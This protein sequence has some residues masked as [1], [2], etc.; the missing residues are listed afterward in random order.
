[1]GLKIINNSDF[2]LLEIEN[3][4]SSL[5]LKNYF[6]FI[7]KNHNKIKGDIFEFGVF[8]GSSLLST[9]LLL[10]SLN[11]KKKVIGFDSFSGFPDY[12]KQDSP[13]FFKKLYLKNQINREHY[14]RILKYQKILTFINKKNK[15]NQISTSGN[16]SNT[17]LQLLKKKLKFLNLSNVILVKG[18]F[19]ETIKRFKR[20]N[21]NINI[22]AANIDCD[23]YDGYKQSLEFIWEFAKKRAYIHLDEYYSLKFPGAKIATDEFLKNK[24][25]KV[26]KFKAKGDDFNRCYLIR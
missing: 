9:A 19:K 26:K 4:N 10:K 24:K 23:L 11:S 2:N 21:S 15:P 6:K 8:R 12:K 3:Y 1:M 17:S 14:N 25:N 7:K 20:N 22:F 18:D 16:F 5:R 13:S